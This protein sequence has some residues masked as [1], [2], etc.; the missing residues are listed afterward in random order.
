MTTAWRNEMSKIYICKECGQETDQYKDGCP[1]CGASKENLIYSMY[2]HDHNDWY[3]SDADDN[4]LD[5]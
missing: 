1:Y 5:E 2:G 3:I 4:Y